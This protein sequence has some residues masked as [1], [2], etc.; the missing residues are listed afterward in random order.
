MALLPYRLGVPRIGILL[1]GQQR[2]GKDVDEKASVAGC[3]LG[4]GMR[5]A[6]RA[7]ALGSGKSTP[8]PGGGEGFHRDRSARCRIGRK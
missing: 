8:A 4:G 7:A 6:G 1:D 2:Y 5:S 3:F